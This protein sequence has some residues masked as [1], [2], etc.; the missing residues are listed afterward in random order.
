MIYATAFLVPGIMPFPLSCPCSASFPFTV[1]FLFL[2]AHDAHFGSTCQHQAPTS[3]LLISP[4]SQIRHHG[5]QISQPY[6]LKTRLITVHPYQVHPPP[7]KHVR[8]PPNP[9]RAFTP[10]SPPKPLPQQ[11]PPAPLTPTP[12]SIRDPHHQAHYRLGHRI[13]RPFLSR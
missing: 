10:T 5:I 9:R 4:K 3:A 13:S 1:C 8:P 6:N 12:D 7:P 11:Y 2:I